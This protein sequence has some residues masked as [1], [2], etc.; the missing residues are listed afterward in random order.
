MIFVNLAPGNPAPWFHAASTSN[1]RYA[2]DT[3]AGRY[4]LMCFFGS[5]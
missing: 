4:I 5:A 2:F 3:A 1:P